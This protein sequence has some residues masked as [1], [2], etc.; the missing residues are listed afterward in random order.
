MRQQI[1]TQ[2]ADLA[3]VLRYLSG[4]YRRPRSER[5]TV[6]IVIAVCVGVAVWTAVDD[7]EEAFW[8]ALLMLAGVIALLDHAAVKYVFSA[9]A[10]ARKSPIPFLSRSVPVARVHEGYLVIG[11]GLSLELV[12]VEGRGLVIPLEGDLRKDFARLYT[13]IGEDPFDTPI[14]DRRWR[15]VIYGFVALLVIALAITTVILARK[16]LVTW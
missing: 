13:E 8:V 3:V 14:L 10:I 9:E 4:E 12:P 5:I 16:G 15:I 7:P 6:W 2:A 1:I 11:N